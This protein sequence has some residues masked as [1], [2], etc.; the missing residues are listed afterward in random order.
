M[1]Y[2]KTYEKFTFPST[3][4]PNMSDKQYWVL[5]Y[6]VRNF[7]DI[8]KFNHEEDLRSGDGGEYH[9]DVLAGS[10]LTESNIKIGDKRPNLVMSRGRIFELEESDRLKLATPDQIELY[11]KYSTINK[12]NL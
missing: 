12:Y 9:F 11:D 8:M 4:F 1:I 6:E 5:T 10:S 2:L 3:I 7:I